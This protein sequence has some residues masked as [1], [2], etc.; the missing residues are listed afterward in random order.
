MASKLKCKW[1]NLDTKVQKLAKLL[2]SVAAIIGVLTAGTAWFLGQIDSAIS[3]KIEDQTATLQQ[4]VKQI[5]SD[6]EATAKQTE[7]QLTRLELLMLMETDPDNAIEIEKVARRYFIDLG[8]NTYM[9]SE[10]SRW[11]KLHNADCEIVFK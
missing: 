4:E 7:L 10:F 9:S 11:C 8:G 6:R 5:A 2:T 1:D 3:N